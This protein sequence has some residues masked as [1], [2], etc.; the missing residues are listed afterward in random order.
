MRDLT[1]EEIKYLKSEINLLAHFAKTMR[2]EEAKAKAG[3]AHFKIDKQLYH[4]HM[5]KV[6]KAIKGI[7]K[8][9]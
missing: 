4:L 3:E 9:I 8:T 6:K 7:A 5:G 2:K 1:K